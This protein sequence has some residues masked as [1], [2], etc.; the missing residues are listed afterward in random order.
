MLTFVIIAL[1]SLKTGPL[2]GDDPWESEGLEW[3][4]SSPPPPYNFHLIPTVSDRYPLWTRTG[5]EPVV[6]GLGSDRREILVTNTLDA[7]L[8]HR[9]TSPG[10]SFSP[11][12]LA[13]GVALT[14]CVSIFTPWGVAIGAVP[15]FLA[16]LAWFWPR[17]D[18]GHTVLKEKKS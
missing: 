9:D 16:L 1:L 13:L 3:F 7:E 10:H 18:Q 15:C 2:A 6:T 4:T 14:F 17:G 5:D 12:F 8:D 11:F